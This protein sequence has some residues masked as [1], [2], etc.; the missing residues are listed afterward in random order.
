MPDGAVILRGSFVLCGSFNV[1]FWFVF[2]LL[3]LLFF[4]SSRLVSK[5]NA[6][7]PT[8]LIVVRR[9]D[10]FGFSDG[11]EAAPITGAPAAHCFCIHR[12][13]SLEDCAA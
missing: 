6:G 7:R 9:N 2:V 5:E 11:T 4:G 10:R 3:A 8:R 13:Q 1:Y 12:D